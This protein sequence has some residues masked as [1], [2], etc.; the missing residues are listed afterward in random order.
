MEI[1]DRFIIPKY[2][3][4]SL[5]TQTTKLFDKFEDEE[6]SSELIAHELGYEQ[7]GTAFYRKLSDFKSYGLLETVG[8]KIRV[9]DLGKQTVV[10]DDAERQRAL[11]EIIHN[12]EL[13]DMLLKKHGKNIEKEKF[14]RYLAEI[15]GVKQSEVQNMAEKVRRAYMED[16]RQIKLVDMA[17]A[18]QEL[19]TVETRDVEA[20]ER[21]TSAEAV[22]TGSENAIV[23]IQYPGYRGH[24][25]IKDTIS[26][27]I[28]K[29]LLEA[30]ELK[31]K[32]KQIPKSTL[33]ESENKA[34][35][36]IFEF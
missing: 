18:P 20:R 5:L 21:I 24:I 14:P 13:W 25:E 23:D 17:L 7:R 34:G 30:I 4:S 26:L 36:R 35:G 11:L 32:E 33:N 15:A 27:E 19:Q 28:V 9:T 12:I 3:L 31:L 6:T 10:G 16:I 8:R 1:G 22:P 29:K 2:R